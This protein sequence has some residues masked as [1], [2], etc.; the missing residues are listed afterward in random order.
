M[1]RKIFFAATMIL[2]L[3]FSAYAQ[4]SMT[5]T[6]YYPSPLGVYDQVRLVPRPSAGVSCNKDADA[7][8]MFYDEVDDLLKVCTPDGIDGWGFVTTASPWTRDAANGRIFPANLGDMVGI[9]TSTPGWDGVNTTL[10]VAGLTRSEAFYTTETN[11]L[12]IQGNTSDM[13]AIVAVCTDVD[14]DTHGLGISVTGAGPIILSGGEVTLA[15]GR[16]NWLRVDG[17]WVGGG[18]PQIVVDGVDPDVGMAIMTKGDGKVG[19]NKTNPAEDLDVVG[20]ILASGTICDKNG[21]I[22]AGGVGDSV[23]HLK[24]EA[25]DA[26]NLPL[27]PAPWK[28]IGP[29][30]EKSNVSPTIWVRTCYRNDQACQVMHMVV[31]EDDISLAQCPSVAE[32]WSEVVPYQK[33]G[34]HAGRNILR[35]TCYRCP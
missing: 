2:A 16:G 22:G 15:S 4:Q 14:S 30:P 17:T 20:N 12:T 27:C 34:A 19:I 10:D 1:F 7:G 6:T 29:Y 23:M 21:C 5:L 28:S 35:R 31:G 11:Y 9:G 8:R 13:P 3:A 33:I 25:V 32:G 26:T 24:R 18:D